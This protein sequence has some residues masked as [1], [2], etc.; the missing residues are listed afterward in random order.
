MSSRRKILFIIPSLRGGGAERTLINL[1]QRIEAEQYEIDLLVIS[2]IGP[3]VNQVPDYV[4]VN[5][6]FKNDFIARICG[7]LHRCFD[8]SY[9]LERK[10]KSLDKTYDVGISFLDTNFTDMLFY[11]E[12]IRKRIAFVHSSYRTHENYERFY[13]RENYN[14]K[15][16]KNRYSRLDAIYFVSEDSMEE[17]TEVLGEYPNM[18]VVYNLMDREA[19]KRKSRESFQLKRKEVFSFS[20]AGSLMKVKGFDRLIRAAAIARDEGYKFVIHLAGTGPE[21][22]N[23]KRLIR[24]NN[25]GET[26]Y[27]YGF[28]SNP[29]P[30]MK[31]SD[32]FVMSSISE[33]LPTVL[34]EA[35]IL[36]VPTLVTN[37]SGCRGLVDRGEYGLMA[38]LDDQDLSE[39][40]MQYMD[41]PGLLDHFR[42]KSLERAE[43]FEDERILEI[44]YDI[45]D[46][47]LPEHTG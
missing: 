10:M 33:A 44:Y 9:I 21:E 22:Q 18:G 1:L 14:K 35:M 12:R 29:Y 25:L 23:L 3:Y 17:F 36:G 27:L 6:L 20:A 46:G 7:L 16:R 30:L 37:C 38:E 47:N 31:Q 13:S 39:K 34:C 28:L 4:E 41:R 19:V 26:V 40:M 8:I 32:V 15:L 45:F 43:L 5:Y 11:T 24:E 42:K 2:K